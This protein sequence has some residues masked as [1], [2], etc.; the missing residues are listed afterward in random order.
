MPVPLPEF[1]GDVTRS[2]LCKLGVEAF[3][4][5]LLSDALSERDPGLS[6]SCRGRF[7]VD[8]GMVVEVDKYLVVEREELTTI[9]LVGSRGVNIHHG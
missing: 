1:I 6:A 4:L 5:C 3:F 9:A 7:W 2:E 8:V